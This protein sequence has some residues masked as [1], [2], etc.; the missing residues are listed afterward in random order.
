MS[1]SCWILNFFS[2]EPFVTPSKYFPPLIP[3]LS[4]LILLVAPMLLVSLYTIP[5]VSID[6]L[7][8]T[9]SFH[10]Y[11]SVGR[12]VTVDSVI[13]ALNVVI[14]PSASYHPMTVS[15]GNVTLY[16][17]LLSVVLGTLSI[18]KFKSE[19]FASSLSFG[20]CMSN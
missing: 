13:F 8:C 17:F 9:R 6:D 10:L 4:G 7:I 14:L 3:Y 1:L 18:E 11:P 19:D 5:M 20:L 16:I 12:P 15:L 2:A